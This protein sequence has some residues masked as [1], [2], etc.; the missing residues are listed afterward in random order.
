[1][2]YRKKPVV[3]EAWQWDETRELLNILVEN[4]MKLARYTPH[5]NENFVKY[6]RVETL[7]GLFYFLKG[8]WI[9]KGVVGEFYPVKPDIF[10]LTY[11]P[12]L[13]DEVTDARCRD[14]G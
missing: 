2:K 6:L 10:E 9:V 12:V 11:E 14:S 13:V 5:E 7:E 8:D 3:V 1:M 4:G